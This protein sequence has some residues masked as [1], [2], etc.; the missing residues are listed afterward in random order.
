MPKAIVSPRELERFASRLDEIARTVVDKRRD[1]SRLV[2]EAGDVWR[3]AKYERFRKV[4][5]ETV[6]ELDRF[7]ARAREYS[8]FL[9]EKARKAQK[10]LDNR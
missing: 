9:R 7:A 8:T 1:K 4:F 5:D 2:A 3:D 6:A 10:Y